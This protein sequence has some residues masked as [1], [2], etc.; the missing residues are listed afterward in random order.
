M[1][2]DKYTK[3]L[4]CL[5]G[6]IIFGIALSRENM[7]SEPFTQ[8]ELYYDKEKGDYIVYNSAKDIVRIKDPKSVDGRIVESRYQYQKQKTEPVLSLNYI[9]NRNVAHNK[10]KDLDCHNKKYGIFSKE[11]CK[12]FMEDISKDSANF[13]IKKE[14]IDNFLKEYPEIANNNPRKAIKFSELS[15]L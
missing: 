7:V 13:D 15:M 6:I 1:K 2:I 3:I 8:S 10:I 11:E 9:S 5:I 4:L 14:M 12:D